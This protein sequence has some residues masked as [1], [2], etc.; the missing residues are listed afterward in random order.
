MSDLVDGLEYKGM[1]MKHGQLK[2]LDVL[3]ALDIVKV[4]AVFFFLL[5]DW[6]FEFYMSLRIELRLISCTGEQTWWPVKDI[7]MFW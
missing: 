1:M 2:S 4:F 5:I 7:Y 6:Y 3:V